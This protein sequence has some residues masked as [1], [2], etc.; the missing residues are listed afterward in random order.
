MIGEDKRMRGIL[1]GYLFEIVVLD[2]L[3]RNDFIPYKP[4]PKVNPFFK[5]EREGFIEFRGRGCWHQIDC[6]CDYRYLIPFIYP[7]RLLGEVK[8]YRKPI[9]KEH[10]RE[11]IG[12]LK[13]IQENYVIA[14]NQGINDLRPRMTEI[15]VF[16]SASGFNPEAENLAY[17]HGIKTISYANNHLINN[18]KK[19]IDKLEENHLSVKCLE[20]DYWHDFRR[21]IIEGLDRGYFDGDVLSSTFLNTASPNYG[22]QHPLND[23]LEAYSKIK[24]CFVASTYSGVILQFFSKSEFPSEL[25]EHTDY[26][27]CRVFY[28]MKRNRRYFWMQFVNINGKLDKRKFYFTPPESLSSAAVHGGSIVLNEKLRIFKA[29]SINIKLSNISRNL[30]IELDR[31]WFDAIAEN[32][33]GNNL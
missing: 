22:N 19:A 16:F 11:F 31:D 2:L 28:T 3:R 6:P 25:F 7:I 8:Y 27:K 24:S 12:V 30:V 23:L 4:N 20:N 29:I 1:K 9:T 15:G 10:V 5:E 18:I 26:R 32:I 33:E 14:V 17:A 13:D 21:E